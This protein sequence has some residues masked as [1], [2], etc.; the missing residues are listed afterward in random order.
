MTRSPHP[1]GLTR[2][3]V[4]RLFAIGGGAALLG[5]SLAGCA[6]ANTRP[7]TSGDVDLSFWTHDDGYIAFFTDAV[8]LAEANSAFRYH[9]DITKAAQDGSF[10]GGANTV[11]DVKSGSVG[12]GKTN[13]VGAKYEAQVQ[14][15]QGKI[16]SG[17][18]TDIPDTVK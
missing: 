13:S 7:S 17:E 10:K 12:I 3:D 9:L 8:P 16:A 2:R 11:F 5:S 6:P 4:L 1:P 14:E 15:V 18:I